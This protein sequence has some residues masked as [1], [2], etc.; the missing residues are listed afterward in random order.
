[1]VKIKDILCVTGLYKVIQGV[2]AL[3]ME[4]VKSVNDLLKNMNLTEQEFEAHRELIEECMENERKINRSCASTKQNIEKISGVLR[5]MS[6]EMAVLSL[7]L[8]NLVD[9]AA[10]LSIRMMPSEKFFHE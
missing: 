4:N 2:A 5:H 3:H 10:T 1:M 9:Q 8:E 6:Q 7:S